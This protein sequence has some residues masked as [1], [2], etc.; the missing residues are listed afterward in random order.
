M[1]STIGYYG[2][3]EL[4]RVNK[5]KARNLFN[6]GIDIHIIPCNASHTY[7]SFVCNVTHQQMHGM[8]WTTIS[9]KQDYT[10]DEIVNQMEYY[11]CNNEIGLYLCY[12]VEEKEGKK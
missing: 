10:F 12:Y 7:G 2:N 5:T 3:K 11:N 8:F 4:K 1:N 6:K 9:N